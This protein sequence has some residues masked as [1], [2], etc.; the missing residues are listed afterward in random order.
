MRKIDLQKIVDSCGLDTKELATE[1]FPTAKFPIPA[2]K[3]ILSGEAQLDANQIARLSHYT[4]LTLDQIFGAPA[5]WKGAKQL[6]EGK[7]NLESGEYRAELDL[8]TWLVKISHKESLFCN[9]ILCSQMVPMSVFINALNEQ[10][11]NHK[12]Q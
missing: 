5:K 9:E 1:L 12:N 3:R 6:S 7:L 8:K 4:G 11:S 2:L 10:V